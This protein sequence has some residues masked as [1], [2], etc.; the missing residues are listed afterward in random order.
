MLICD[1]LQ[2]ERDQW[3]ALKKPPSPLSPLFPPESDPTSPS[4]IDASLLDPEQAAILSSIISLPAEDLRSQTTQRLKAIQSGLEFKI[5]QFAD[6]VHK[7]EQFQETAGRV[8]DK[9]LSMSAVRLEARERKEKESVGTRDVPMQ[10]VL[11][12]L[13]RILP[14]EGGNR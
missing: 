5:D 12:S 4:Q 2:E 8:A 6:G 14:A 1:S 9:I 7:M 10:E 13:S 11:S 3:K